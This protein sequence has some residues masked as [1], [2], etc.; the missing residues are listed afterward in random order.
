VIR[1]QLRRLLVILGAGYVVALVVAVV[2]W[3]NGHTVIRL[4]AEEARVIAEEARQS[5][6]ARAVFAG[7]LARPPGKVRPGR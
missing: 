3:R 7:L 5:R 1:R 6:E 2:I 4:L